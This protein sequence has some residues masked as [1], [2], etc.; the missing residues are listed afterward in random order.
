MAARSDAA[1][2]SAARSGDRDAFAALV[3]RHHPALL[4]AC[5]G[6]PDVAQEAV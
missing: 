2:V 3:E 4:R 5:P 6:S 1:L